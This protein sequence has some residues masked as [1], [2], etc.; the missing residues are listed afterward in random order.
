MIGRAFFH[1]GRM[2]RETGQALDRLGLRSQNNFVFRDKLSRH[3]AVMNLYE[4]RPSMAADVFV[5]PSASVIG[6]VILNDGVSVWYGAVVRSD[7]NPVTIG[8]YTNI[9]ERAV[10]H[11]ATSTPTGFKAN[12]S[13]G[14]WV[15]VGQGAVLR[16]CTVE[17]YCVI[18]AGSV[19]LEGSLVEKHAIVEPG[20]VLP[21]GGR[22]PSGEMWGGNPIAFVRKLSKEEAADIEKQA[23]AVADAAKEHQ[24]QFLPYGTTYQLRS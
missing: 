4:K 15:S 2:L 14:S 20:S 6:D 22:V 1:A 19:L 8:G 7:V 23:N 24:E 9:Q 10:V 11:A 13:I 21:A 18:G 16:A 17:D 3:R 12:C 5:A